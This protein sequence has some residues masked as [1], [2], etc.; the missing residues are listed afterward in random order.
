MKSIYKS[1]GNVQFVKVGRSDMDKLESLIALRVGG[2]I[3]IDELDAQMKEE[4][5]VKKEIEE[6]ELDLDAV[7]EVLFYCD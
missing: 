4:E 2:M 5:E 3:T 1:I 6:L 7:V